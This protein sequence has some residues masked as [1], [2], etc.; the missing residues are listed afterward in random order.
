MMRYKLCN[1]LIVVTVS[2]AGRRVGSPPLPDLNQQ[3]SCVLF[4]VFTVWK[5]VNCSVGYRNVLTKHSLKEV[6]LTMIDY[7]RVSNL[8]AFNA[9]FCMSHCKQL[10]VLHYQ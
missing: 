10:S 7:F 6:S 3:Y 9:L 8:N 4:R 1:V 2:L 5:V